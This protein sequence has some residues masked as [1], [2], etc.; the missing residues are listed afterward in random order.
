VI[1]TIFNNPG[2]IPQKI[3]L[4][5]QN[6]KVYQNFIQNPSLSDIGDRYYSFMKYCQ[7]NIKYSKKIN[8]FQFIH[9]VSFFGVLKI[10]EKIKSM[11]K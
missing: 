5:L 8:T 3:E 9:I 6:Y 1:T 7:N 2:E 11:K 4:I 10:L